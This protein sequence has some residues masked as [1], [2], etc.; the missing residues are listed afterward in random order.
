MA[1]RWFQ[2]FSNYTKYSS[3]CYLYDLF[4]R[5]YPI[6]TNASNVFHSPRLKTSVKK[7][8][9]LKSQSNATRLVAKPFLKIHPSPR[10]GM[11][12]HPLSVWTVPF[13]ASNKFHDLIGSLP[14]RSYKG[15][16]TSRYSSYMFKSL[17]KKKYR[18]AKKT[19]WLPTKL[20]FGKINLFRKYISSKV[21]IENRDLSELVILQTRRNLPTRVRARRIYSKP[22][23]RFIPYKY[24][25]VELP[26]RALE[27]HPSSFFAEFWDE[28]ETQGL[29]NGHSSPHKFVLNS[30]FKPVPK[31]QRFF[32][33]FHRRFPRRLQKRFRWLR[34]L[35]SLKFKQYKKEPNAENTEF[36]NCFSKRWRYPTR[37]LNSSIPR[38]PFLSSK[39]DSKGCQPIYSQV[40]FWPRK[41]IRRRVKRENK[42]FF[43]HLYRV[44][45][46]STPKN[47]ICGVRFANAFYLASTLWIRNLLRS[48]PARLK[49]GRLRRRFRTSIRDMRTTLFTLKSSL[50]F[51]NPT[52][53]LR[54]EHSAYRPY[55]T[56]YNLPTRVQDAIPSGLRLLTPQLNTELLCD[57]DDFVI[58]CPAVRKGSHYHSTQI[59]VSEFSSVLRKITSN[60]NINVGY[61]YNKVITRTQNF[62][63]S[64]SKSED[65]IRIFPTHSF[66][67]RRSLFFFTHLVLRPS[68]VQLDLLASNPTLLPFFDYHVF[69]DANLI[70]VDAF[71]RLNRQKNLFL[72]RHQLFNYLKTLDPVS[73]FESVPTFRQN[74]PAKPSTTRH[75]LQVRSSVALR[76]LVTPY[77]NMQHA[78]RSIY[79]TVR[80]Q[81]VRFKPGY[82]RIWRE[83]R[84]SI[85]EI[86]NV[87]VRY[88]YRLTPKLHWLYLQD[89]KLIR[90]YSPSSIDYLLLAS[91]IIPDFWSLNELTFS[92][93]LFLN[94]R[95]VQNLNLK[96]FVNDFIQVVVNLRFYIA[97]KWLKVWSEMRQNRVNR[98]F[99]S[100]YRPSGTNRNYRFARPL[101][102]WF[103]DIRFAYRDIP[104]HVEVDFFTLSLFVLYDKRPHDQNEPVRANLYDSSSLNMYNWKYIT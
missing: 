7:F 54:Q 60:F 23:P 58:K 98:V 67:F 74:H 35:Y 37:Y 44:H 104:Q 93:S 47:F 87:P 6:R 26:T 81:R 91:H 101:P 53:T 57:I 12:R 28:L 69:P 88:Q 76:R 99:Y 94:G 97:F 30:E 33:L 82:G 52:L 8:P 19:V 85:R 16:S 70:K 86:A 2:N 65:T 21:D 51:L 96:V 45:L 14:L 71:R 22:L 95:T 25:N 42:Y 46:Q 38:K 66:L 59:K 34:Y 73:A 78:S 40:S 41:L 17:Q 20:S 15:D 1:F 72:A 89:R 90:K 24:L 10:K 5:S 75:P 27:A 92:N 31:M 3:F 32:N 29:R 84:T 49:S 11:V 80:I 79:R 50:F 83:A 43:K 100:K 4:S 36:R 62:K 64:S 55:Q 77:Q 48:K 56:S 18:K 103:F 61:F 63:F 102:S 9:F 68:S 13:I 39:D